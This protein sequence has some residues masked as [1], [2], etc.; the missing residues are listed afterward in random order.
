MDSMDGDGTDQEL[1]AEVVA[2]VNELAGEILRTIDYY[3]VQNR[4]VSILQVYL[5]GGGARTDQ[6]PDLLARA[7]ELPVFVHDPLENMEISPSFNQKYLR[8]VSPRMAVAVGLA[9]RG[10]EK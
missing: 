8:G 5:T 1:Q 6:V 3:R 10:I 4:S 7:L 9:L 2:N